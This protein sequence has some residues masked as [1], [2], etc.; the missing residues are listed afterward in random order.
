MMVKVQQLLLLAVFDALALVNDAY[1]VARSQRRQ[2]RSQD[3]NDSTLKDHHNSVE[4]EPWEVNEGLNASFFQ[5]DIILSPSLLKMIHKNSSTRRKRAIKKDPASRW[6]NAIVPFS[7]DKRLSQNAKVQIRKAIKHWKRHTC[8]NF[9]KKRAGDKDYIHFVAEDG[10]WSSVGRQGGEQK[11][12][13]G[14]GCEYFGTIIHEIGHAMGMWHEQSR[15]D[16]DIY[17]KVI[18]DNIEPKYKDQFSKMNSSVMDSMGYAYDYESIMHYGSKFF[19]K[20]KKHTLRI[21]KPGRDVGVRIGQRKRLSYLD[22]A[23]IRAMYNCNKI[24][25]SAPCLKNRKTKG[26]DYRGKLDYTEQGV[27]CQPWDKQW[28]HK[29]KDVSPKKYYKDYTNGLMEMNSRGLFVYHNYCRNPNGKRN[30]PWCYT[31]LQRPEWQYC[32]LKFC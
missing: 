11:I 3:L 15:T 18:K 10:C 22:I 1:P 24:P 14:N 31:T 6:T 32:D 28:P 26:R 16:R 9:R 8:I 25:A 4:K 12:G 5:G 29:H 23:Q 17:V 27:T 19:T 21:R 2:A 7:Y 30:R 20:N 13:V